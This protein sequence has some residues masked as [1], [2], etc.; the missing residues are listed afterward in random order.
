MWFDWVR[1]AGAVYLVWLGW[2]LLRANAGFGE[3]GRTPKPRGGFFLQGFLVLMSNPKALLWFGAF[4]PQFVDPAGNYV[5]QIMLLGATAM[6]TAALTDGAYAMLGGRTGRFM[7]AQAHSPRL[8][9]ERLVPDR[10]RRLARVHP[11]AI[12]TAR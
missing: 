12:T 1:I 3:V 8:A 10:R 2:K 7:S 9:I 6:A 5:G 4:I 11:R